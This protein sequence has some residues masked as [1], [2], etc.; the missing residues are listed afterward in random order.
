MRLAEEVSAPST[1][2]VSDMLMY[3]CLQGKGRVR[4]V[5]Q[6]RGI[7]QKYRKYF[8]HEKEGA[9]PV[10][11]LGSCHPA[12]RIMRFISLATG[13]VQLPFEGENSCGR[14]DIGCQ[15]VPV[16]WQFILKYVCA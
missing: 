12:Y 13:T 5:M 7:R 14:C 11:N 3:I 9:Q 8:L 15:C 16:F 4:N 2:R 1:D 6:P 10:S